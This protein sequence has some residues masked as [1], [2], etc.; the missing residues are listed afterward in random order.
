MQ[1]P[2]ATSIGNATGPC[3]K[4]PPRLMVI[5]D[6]LG[7]VDHPRSHSVSIKG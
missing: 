5:T 6:L 1:A 7:A 4:A 3:G 2:K